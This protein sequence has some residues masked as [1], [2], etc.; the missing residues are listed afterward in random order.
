L[1]AARLLRAI[2]DD[3]TVFILIEL[4]RDIEPEVKLEAIH[5]AR[6]S[7][8]PETWGILTELLDSGT[9]GHAA[10][11][12]LVESGSPVLDFLES[13]FHR[14]GQTRE[15]QLIIVEII[16]RIGN[17][18]A[19]ELLWNKIDYPDRK[20]VRKILEKFDDLNFKA[21]DSQVNKL[22]E[23][24]DDE[25]GKAIWNLAAIDEISDKPENALLKDA[26]KYEVVSNYEFI[27]L[28]LG[29][30]YGKENIDLVKS[31]IEA[32]TS[33]GTAYALELLDIFLIKDLKPKLFALFDDIKT[34]DK[35]KRLQ[36]YYPR[37]SY[38]ESQSLN[39]ILN[40]DFNS[41]NRWTK[42][43]ALE[44]LQNSPE[45]KLTKGVV[46]HLFNPDK[47]IAQSAARIIYNKSRGT[48]VSISKRL[49]ENTKKE[50]DEMLLYQNAQDHIRDPFPYDFDKTRYLLTLPEFDPLLPVIVSQIASKMEAH[51]I[52]K[53]T[54]VSPRSDIRKNRPISIVAKGSIQLCENENPVFTI[55]KDNLFGDLFMLDNDRDIT[56]LYALEDSI[57]YTISNN[58][59]FLI[60]SNYPE[61]AKDFVKGIA[62]KIDLELTK[63]RA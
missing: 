15:S 24:L 43:C 26:L 20:I 50:L 19:I 29:L 37:E 13:Q 21:T 56:R 34:S 49:D 14:S 8:R 31:N 7:K 9:Y 42:V 61:L 54:S 59:F 47:M 62:E 55:S 11:S 32:D 53:G 12:A 23:S 18:K 5:A 3:D 4:L 17:R 28:L 44:G 10:A 52:A 2:S 22:Y 1:L 38:N 16:G 36:E 60:V 63:T 58:D 33:D 57:I 35:L 46:A 6:I 27:Y 25:I 30:I 40:R 41:I 51:F 45:F 39:Y 48:Y